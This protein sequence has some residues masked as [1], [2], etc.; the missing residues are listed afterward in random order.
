M[1][2]FSLKTRSR[3]TPPA[4]HV[5]SV[6]R[7]ALGRSI[8]SVIIVVIVFGF[9]TCLIGYFLGAD[10]NWDLQNYHFYNG[11]LYTNGKLFSDS[12]ATVQ[13]YLDPLLNAFYYRLIS[14]LSPLVVNM[15]IAFLQ[16]LALV[17]IF[18]LSKHVLLD[19]TC[20]HR[21]L[22][23]TLLAISALIGP[24]FWSEIG[25]TMGDTLLATPVIVSVFLLARYV[26]LAAAGQ[27]RPVYVMLAGLAIGLVSGL[28]FTNM[29]YALS[30]FLSLGIILGWQ[31]KIGIKKAAIAAAAFSV[32]AMVGFVIIYG[33]VGWL[34]WKHFQNPIFPYFN[35]IFRSPYVRPYAWHDTRW[36][37]KS[38]IGYLEIPFATF[39][40]H[41]ERAGGME[42][43]FRN[44]FFGLIFIFIVLSIWS[45]RRKEDPASPPDLGRAFLVLFFVIGFVIW[46]YMFGYYRYLAVLELLA[47]GMMFI[48]TCSV[49]PKNLE[50]SRVTAAIVVF[51][52]ALSNLPDPNWRREA[53][54]STY[55]GLRKATFKEYQHCLL[56][57]GQE[58]MGF[59]LPYF[60][61]SVRVVGLPERIGFTR[62]FTKHYFARLYHFSGP[63]YYVVRYKGSLRASIAGA[64]S[65]SSYNLV[66]SDKCRK[67]ATH[68]FALEICAV[69][70]V[71]DGQYT[72]T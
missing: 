10:L 45:R 61:S 39:I 32:S 28:K 18:F 31:K 12:L 26:S 35:N 13:S 44:S 47:P 30:A 69:K 51:M 71:R 25:G 49:L 57:V 72:H 43:G 58:P 20:R 59:F 7:G 2:T 33:H 37:P 14:S 70:R 67:V 36:L 5:V 3:Q 19:K 55:F 62:K 1:S 17:A 27:E 16:S 24:I 34:L 41:T 64:P 53:F 46:A 4:G 48:V 8:L 63:M 56:I 6:G 54:S 52:V 9:I 40:F 23:P 50:L 66:I 42:I 38:L 29:T 15:V 22:I 65:L 68:V 21:I 11:Y 60:P